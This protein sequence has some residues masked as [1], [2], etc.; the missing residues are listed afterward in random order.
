MSS[1]FYINLVNKNTKEEICLLDL[2]EIPARELNEGVNLAYD[3]STLLTKD[4]FIEICD[5]YKKQIKAREENIK[6][7]EEDQSKLFSTISNATSKEVVNELYDIILEDNKNIDWCKAEIKEK[8]KYL[9]DL[10]HVWE[11]LELNTDFGVNGKNYELWYYF[12]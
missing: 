7:N 3:K 12:S 4:F 2:C 10:E 1:C 6:R 5:Y 11:I 9:S 8:E